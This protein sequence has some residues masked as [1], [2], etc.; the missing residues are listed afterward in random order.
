MKNISYG[1]NIGREVDGEEQY[2]RYLTFTN[3]EAA[4]Q[5]FDVL[6][7]GSEQDMWDCV[8]IEEITETDR[9][10]FDYEVI[11]R[12]RILEKSSVYGGHYESGRKTRI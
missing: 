2:D 11:I 10:D 9:G 8:E 7:M 5:V 12:A 1:V 6:I 4:K 3:Y